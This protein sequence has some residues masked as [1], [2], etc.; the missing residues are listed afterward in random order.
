MKIQ[1]I[2][3]NGLH[4]RTKKRKVL[5][6]LKKLRAD[7]GF[8]QELHFKTGEIRYLKRYWVGE[9]FDSI[10]FSNRGVGILKQRCSFFSRI[11]IQG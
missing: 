7:T 11:H 6:H 10:N 1:S 5:D 3:W 8:L 4:D 2:S 9:A